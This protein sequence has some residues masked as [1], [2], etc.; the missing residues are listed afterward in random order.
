VDFCL[1]DTGAMFGHS[2]QPVAD[3]IARQAQTDQAGDALGWLLE[4]EVQR[5]QRQRQSATTKRVL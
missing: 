5:Q 1:G 3:A 4:A 2:P